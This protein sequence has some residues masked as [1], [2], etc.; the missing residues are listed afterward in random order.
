[1]YIPSHFA[2]ND[3]ERMVSH[4]SENAYQ[5]AD[6]KLNLKQKIEFFKNEQSTLF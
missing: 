2:E 1:M 6:K 4:M 3:L 5:Q